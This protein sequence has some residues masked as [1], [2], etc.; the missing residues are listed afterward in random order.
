MAPGGAISIRAARSSDKR[1]VA[2]VCSLIWEDD[3]VPR[4]FDGWVRD[5]RGRLWVAC[6]NGRVVAV[7]KLTLTGDREAWLHA[8]RVEPRYRRLGVATALLAHRLERARR[9]GARVARLDTWEGNVAV[10]RLM[11][12]FG[13]SPVIRFAHLSARARTGDAPR[14]ARIEQVPKLWRLSRDSDGLIQ[15]GSIGHFRRRIAR[16]DLVRAIR[17]RRCLIAGDGDEPAAAAIVEPGDDAIRL[18][19]L[20][21]RGRAVRELLSGLRAEALR[22]RKK[23]VGLNLWSKWWRAAE[24]AGYRKRWPDAHVVFERKL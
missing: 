9:L 23:R 5:R 8:L 17:A 19:Y 2:R 1:A 6:V 3:Y 18:S 10:R 14:R 21:G 16:S 13:F 20:A 7:A 22:Q 11:R 15:E 12:R 24:A 4:A